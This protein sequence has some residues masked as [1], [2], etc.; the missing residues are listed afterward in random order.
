MLWGSDS[1]RQ[2]LP[3]RGNPGESPTGDRASAKGC[4]PLRHPVVIGVLPAC[5]LE[6]SPPSP[7]LSCEW[8][9]MTSWSSWMLAPA[10]EYVSEDLG[11]AT[12]GL[13]RAWWGA[14]PASWPG[15]RC[16]QTLLASQTEILGCHD[17][18]VKNLGLGCTNVA[19]DG[20]H[21]TPIL[22]RASLPRAWVPVCPMGARLVLF[23]ATS[24]RACPGRRTPS[25][26]SRRLPSVYLA[27]VMQDIRLRLSWAVP[28]R[29]RDEGAPSV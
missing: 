9:R 27:V 14:F 11:T 10:G 19:P 5:T 18:V 23:A 22:P 17:A 3:R 29:P 12:M 25:V 6:A 15:A 28:N 13:V 4:R 26:S 20:S 16:P 21:L 8:P 2:A 7:S 1:S 24:S